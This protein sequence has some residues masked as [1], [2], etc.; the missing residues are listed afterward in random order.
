MSQPVAAPVTAATPASYEAALLAAAERD[1]RVMVLTAENRAAIRGLP[2]KL[3]DRFI[4]FGICE[5][6]MIG[7]AAGLALRGRIPV[8]HALATFLTLR[9][10]EFIR[11]DVGISGL[12]V[13][14][15]G[16]VPGFLSD[17]NG[18]THQAIEDVALMRGIP[19]MQVICPTDE[20][21]LVQALPEILASDRPA[22]IR[23]IAGPAKFAHSARFELGRAERLADGHHVTLL[24]YGLLV[25]EVVTAA[26]LL[27]E[28][29]VS[30]R[31][32]NLRSLVPLDQAAVLEAARETAALVTI[33]DH[34]VT[35]GLFSITAELAARNR[36]TTPIVP[37]ALEGRWF[38]PALLPD[39]LRTEGFTAP[40]LAT[41][42]ER[43]LRGLGVLPSE[44]KEGE[45]H[46]PGQTA[47][48]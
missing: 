3:G 33:E 45:R 6:T 1:E 47:V 21:E 40:Q 34:F 30:A 13:K 9:A 32:L 18:P 35:G 15:V 41:R 42:I 38:R 44:S 12:P 31:V 17:A 5:Q 22:Y 48:D 39:V 37:I 26:A 8:A 23:Y 14:L 16:G 43:A 11:T 7:A 4:D 28:R 2:D 27:A 20:D 19:G 24:S 46:V 29:G 25:R 10:F 36:V